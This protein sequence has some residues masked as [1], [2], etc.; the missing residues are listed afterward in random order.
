MEFQ[1]HNKWKKRK[2]LGKTQRRKGAQGKPGDSNER[3]AQRTER[4]AQRTAEREWAT[5]SLFSLKKY[6]M[7][8]VQS[9]VST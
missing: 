6:D 9:K 3:K 8:L 4:K 1:E 7:E 5:E 2:I